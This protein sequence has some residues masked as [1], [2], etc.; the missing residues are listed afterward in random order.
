MK[1]QLILFALSALVLLFA[2]YGCSDDDY[3]SDREIQQMIDESLNG[4][5]QVIPVDINGGDWQWHED[6][7]EA[8]YWAEVELP[9]LKDYIFDDGVAL[10]YYN[11]N[12][13]SKTVLPYVKTTIAGNG[14]PFTETYS[15]DFTLGN[16]S[17]ATFFLEASDAGRYDGNPPG[18][19]FKIVLIY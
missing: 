12:E 4:Q 11:F 15:C 7:V 9:E 8:Y 6:E 5:W 2:G 19:Q 18:A 3:L 17:T 16:P 14:I 1:K 13:N 10:A